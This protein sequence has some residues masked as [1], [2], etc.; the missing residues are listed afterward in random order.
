MECPFA[1]IIPIFWRRKNYGKISTRSE[2]DEAELKQVYVEFVQFVDDIL[3]RKNI[4]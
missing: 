4:L 2:L 1:K 3:V